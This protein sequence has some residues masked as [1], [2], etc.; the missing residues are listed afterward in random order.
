MSKEFERK[1]QTSETFME[2]AL[3]VPGASAPGA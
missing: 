1:I 2:V 3:L